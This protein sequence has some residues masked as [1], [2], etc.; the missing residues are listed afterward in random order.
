MLQ[1]DLLTK[2]FN[3]VVSIEERVDKMVTK[4]EFEQKNN[5]VINHIDG[6][7][8]LHQTLDIELVA[9]RDKYNRLEERLTRV[10][11]RYAQAT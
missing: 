3:K 9:L 7:V 2:I 8:K 11:Q 4:D 5:E 1:D 6:F 10:E